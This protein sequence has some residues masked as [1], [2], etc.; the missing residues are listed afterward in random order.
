[1]SKL[2]V[3]PPKRAQKVNK[4]TCEYTLDL[5]PEPG[6]GSPPGFM[7]IQHSPLKEIPLE[8][9]KFAAGSS[10]TPP[11]EPA[12]AGSQENM[13]GDDTKTENMT[14]E[15]SKVEKM[16]EFF[17]ICGVKELNKF[18]TDCKY[19]L[20]KL[21]MEGGKRYYLLPESI[22]DEASKLEDDLDSKDNK[23]TMQEKISKFYTRAMGI[24]A[25][26]TLGVLVPGQVEVI[27]KLHE[28][29]EEM[30][31]N[32]TTIG[33][34]LRSILGKFEF[35][36]R[37]N[38]AINMSLTKSTKAITDLKSEVKSYREENK[39]LRQELSL[40]EF[41]GQS[42]VSQQPGYVGPFDPA[43]AHNVE[44]GFGFDVSHPGATELRNQTN[45][46]RKEAKKTNGH[47]GIRKDLHSSSNVGV[48]TGNGS[49]AGLRSGGG[50]GVGHVMD[51]GQESDQN[52]GRDHS[53]YS[54]GRGQAQNGENNGGFVYPRGRRNNARNNP[55]PETE[56]VRK[57]Y[58]E[59]L[60]DREFIFHGV[61]EQ[62]PAT[63]SAGTEVELVQ[64]LF[65]ELGV[66][67]LKHFG[68][69]VDMMND[70]A[71]QIRLNNHWEADPLHKKGPNGR[72]CPPIKVRMKSEKICNKVIKAAEKGGC[73]SGR[74][75]VYIGKYRDQRKMDRD[76]LEVEIDLTVAGMATNR[77]SYYIRQSIP[78]EKRDK[79]KLS[80]EQ[81]ALDGQNGQIDPK[82]QKWKERSDEIKKNTILYGDIR[83]FAHGKVDEINNTMRENKKIREDKAAALRQKKVDEKIEKAAMND[84]LHKNTGI[85]GA[86]WGIP[87]L[88]V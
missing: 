67:H 44:T 8:K 78:K 55:N 60:M 31:T 68:V 40:S 17:N 83:N 75:A 14:A 38:K 10:T 85:M 23:K 63:F 39:K 51:Q 25:E 70:V 66:E 6:G 82:A 42:H 33:A 58:Q 49:G 16:G 59:K 80:K 35:Y 20:N 21:V 76:G 12:V 87:A 47:P 57:S 41:Q 50:P 18:R 52:E 1:M 45:Q 43:F 11:A 5:L 54:Q 15:A 74:R 77:P 69:D 86:A 22:Y 13:A 61:E 84:A 71:S 29:E 32:M 9:F 26:Q 36:E 2:R 24:M 37:E 56:A 62:D 48:T 46:K 27:S 3:F 72:G 28:V 64:E 53:Q 4:E 65:T 30:S 19:G 81:K 34:T 88:E 73:L 7:A 79:I